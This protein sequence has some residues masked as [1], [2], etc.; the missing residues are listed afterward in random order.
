MTARRLLFPAIHVRDVPMRPKGAGH[1][2][3]D[4]AQ[5]CARAAKAREIPSRYS[6]IERKAKS[7]GLDEVVSERRRKGEVFEV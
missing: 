2:R 5:A 7:A 1:W 6:G 3:A 4:W